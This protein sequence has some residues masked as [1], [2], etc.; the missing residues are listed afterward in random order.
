M[1]NLDEYISKCEIT[2]FLKNPL[3]AHNSYYDHQRLVSLISNQSS[4]FSVKKGVVTE[5]CLKL[6]LE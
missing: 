6:F 3:T 1:S 5:C 4:V 2:P